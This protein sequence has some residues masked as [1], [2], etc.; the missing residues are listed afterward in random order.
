MSKCKVMLIQPPYTLPRKKQKSLVLP[1]GLC[2][3]AAVLEQDGVEVAILDCFEQ[4]YTT[5][6][7]SGENNV[8]CGLTDEQI[9]QR[10]R[11]FSPDFV[12]VS[13]LFSLAA[14]NAYRVC[15]IAKK[16]SP[17][18]RVVVGGHHPSFLA[19]RMLRE[20]ECM[21]YVVL[22][23]GEYTL[24]DLV[25][26][27][28][29]N[30]ADLSDIDGLVYRDS[31]RVAV[32]PKTRWIENLDEIPV[33][34][35]RLCNVNHY[36]AVDLPQSGRAGRNGMS[37]SLTVISSRGCPR[38]CIFCGTVHLWGRR[39]RTRS[40]ENF[41]AEL[42]SLKRDY[43]LQEFQLQ[44]DNFTFNRNRVMKILD[45]FIEKKLDMQWCTPQGI[46]VMTLD[47]ELIAKMK[48]SGCR[49]I[50]LAIET[51]NE[52]VNRDIIG[53]PIK[54]DH[55]REV[56]KWLKEFEILSQGFFIIGLPGETKATIENTLQFADSLDLDRAQVFIATALPGTRLYELSAEKG[57]LVSG[58]DFDNISGYGSGCLQTEEFNPQYLEELQ[59]RFT[60]KTFV[61]SLR[62]HP[63]KYGWQY[64]KNFVQSPR[65]I[66]NL[67][68]RQG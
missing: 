66:L 39:Y 37:R 53:K 51:G 18:I 67:V 31:G 10:I 3:L 55:V 19:D 56:V 6:V 44:D 65:M 40:P 64:M 11:D 34:A 21:D 32:N 68:R 14:K 27:H 9:E 22:G 57:Y 16:V 1:M 43:S 13:I 17:D 28:V 61:K 33:P 46:D 62:K 23:E 45:L 59:F 8:R 35:R 7:A 2:Y 29:R 54:L 60:R 48:R 36:F 50:T 26:K 63:V 20:H 24:R 4:G 15:E 5:E 41:V 30:D 49:E 47:R 12:G 25:R 42:E 58:F 52:S 38:S